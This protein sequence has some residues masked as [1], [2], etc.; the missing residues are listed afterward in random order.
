MNKLKLSGFL[1]TLF[2]SSLAWAQSSVQ[3]TITDSNGETIV[4]VTVQVQGTTTG[5]ITDIDG[6][7]SI[8]AESDAVLICSFVGFER[9]TVNVNGRARIDVVFEDDLQH[10]EEVMVSA[11]GFKQNKE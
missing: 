11:L 8:N 10:L 1:F 9:Q 7:Y 2:F 6:N 4:G 5:T 3:G